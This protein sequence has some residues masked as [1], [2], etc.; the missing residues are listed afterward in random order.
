MTNGP[1]CT[2]QT[3]SNKSGIW[4]TVELL[5]H[6]IELGELIMFRAKLVRMIGDEEPLLAV[7]DC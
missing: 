4:D 7:L 3:H 5:D 6:Y 1:D 2:H